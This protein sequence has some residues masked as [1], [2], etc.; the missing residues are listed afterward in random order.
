MS[1]IHFSDIVRQTLQKSADS[2]TKKE[3][4]DRVV[5]DKS[6]MSFFNRKL[7]K[8]LNDQIAEGRIATEFDHLGVT[9][10]K[11]IE[12]PVK[13]KPVAPKVEEQPQEAPKSDLDRVKEDLGVEELSNEFQMGYTRGYNDAM[14]HGHREA[15]NAGR[16][17]VL[18]G[19]L[20]L[21]NIKGEIR[22]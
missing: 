9:R 14:F 4:A 21:L 17:N 1:K 12:N 16:Q 11:L 7:S 18:K 22:L 13:K 5:W 2:L 15:Y 20:K 10:Y 19:L 8:T 6:D 3:L